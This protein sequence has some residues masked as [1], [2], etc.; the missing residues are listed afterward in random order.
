MGIALVI[1]AAGKGT[2][3]NSDLPKVLHPLAQAPM[4]AHALAAGRALEPERVVVVA[5][6]GA[7]AVTKAMADLDEEAR[8]VLQTE[9]LGTA[10]AVAQARDALADFAGD[11]VV[12]YGDTPFISAGTL[13]RMTRARA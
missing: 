1:L 7:E 6:H 11:V 8:V 2:R 13:E 10:H 12:L 9:Q 4:L 3:M 5:G